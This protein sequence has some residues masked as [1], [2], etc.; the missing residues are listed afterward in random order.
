MVSKHLNV[1]TFI[2][3]NRMVWEE[4][5]RSDHP[6]SNQLVCAVKFKS[7]NQTFTL[8][9]TVRLLAKASFTVKGYRH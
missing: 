4:F 7:I 6:F 8:R 1:V 3:S 2:Y 9:H 5:K